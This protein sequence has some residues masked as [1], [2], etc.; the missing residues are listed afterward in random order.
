MKIYIDG[1]TKTVYEK[2]DGNLILK[3]K[4]DVTGEGGQADP[5]ANQVLG[6][7][8][9]KGRSSLLLSQHFFALLER[10]GIE[11]HYIS[12][13]PKENTMEVKRAKPYGQGL[14]FICRLRAYGSFLRRYG[15]YA[16]ELQPLNHLVEITIKDDDRGDP[17]INED[18]VVEL[19]LMTQE[20][21]A[22]AKKL[23]RRATRVVEESLAE[24]GLTLIDIKFEFGSVDGRIVLMDEVS[25]DCMRV[26]DHDGDFLAQKDLYRKMFNN[27]M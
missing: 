18:T 13:D 3:F 27:D 15:K 16:R 8:E 4:D 22:K 1:K 26:M 19:N 6:A 21:L 12:A 7:V 5:G 9:G 10:K 23:T 14:E 25:G 20:D 11:T 24:N 17:L 2:P